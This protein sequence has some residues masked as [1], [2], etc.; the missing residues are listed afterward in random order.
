MFEI[1]LQAGSFGLIAWL[2]VFVAPKVVQVLV[3]GLNA[4]NEL[5]LA[6]VVHGKALLVL[7]TKV[8]N[9]CADVSEQVDVV[10]KEL[11]H[12]ENSS[13]QPTTKPDR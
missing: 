3:T 13:R 11:E 9:P 12:I 7:S 1:V 4:I 10:R 5:K 6:L 2:V 8:Q